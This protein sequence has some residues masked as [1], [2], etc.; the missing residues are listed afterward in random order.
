[1]VKQE[2]RLRYDP[3]SGTWQLRALTSLDVNERYPG[4]A[5]WFDDRTGALVQF[6]G[7][8][9]HAQGNTLTT[10]VD[11]I[12]FGAVFGW[13]FRLLIAVLGLVVAGLSLS[14]VW[15]GWGK[16]RR[17]RVAEVVARSTS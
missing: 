2:E 9:G 11:A 16:G 8:T 6:H 4:T 10:W 14:G 15:I 7:P 12:H 3:G 13:P 5:V 17:R 1:M